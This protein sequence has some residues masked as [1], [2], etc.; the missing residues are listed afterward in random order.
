MATINSTGNLVW[1]I[2]EFATK[3]AEARVKEGA[4]LV[5]PAFLTSQYG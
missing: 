3:L 5:S 4:E 1:R 2:P